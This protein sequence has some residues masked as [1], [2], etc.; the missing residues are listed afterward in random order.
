ML[1]KDNQVKWTE[2]AVKSFNLVKL[3]LSSAPI[4]ISPN[5]TQDFIFFSFSSE[6]TLTVVLMQKREDVEKPIT[7]FSWIIRDGA[8]KYNIIEKQAL[9]LVKALK[10]FRVY[11]L[12]SHILAYVPNAAV[13]DILVQA[14]PEGRRGKWIAAL[15]EY[16]VEIKPTKLIKG[17]GLAKLMDETNL[18][19]L[20]IN[21]IAAISDEEENPFVQAVKNCHECQI[22]EGKQKLQPLPLKPIEL[23]APFQQW[24]LD[25]IGEIHPASSGQHRWI[26]TTT[27]YFTKWIEA[28]P[29]RQ[30]TD[31]VIISFLETNILSHFGCPSK[32]ITDN[33]AVL[34]SKRMI[35]FCYKYNISLGHS[36]A[37]HP[38]GNGLAESSNKSLVNIIKKLL[39]ISKKGWHKKLINALWADRVSQKKS[40]GMSPFE[41][42]YGRDTVFPT[43]LAVP[44][45][46]LLQEAGSEED[47]MQ[48]RINQMIHL[49]QTR[50]EVFQNTCKLQE[51]IK[52]IYDQKAKADT[53]QLDEVVL[54]W[55]ARHEDKGKHGKFE[56]L[57]KGPYKIEAYRGQNAFLL[58]EMNGYECPGGPINGRLLKRYYF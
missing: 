19:V 4:L 42:V 12:H 37:Y 26:L 32:L 16:D 2:E 11:I 33:A 24:G 38:Q 23:N 25:F 40:I 28:I 54:R 30:A 20:H 7:F 49:Q 17:Q 52:N 1:K 58:K 50:E 39:E 36:T 31:A 46:K 13:K 21:L 57:W 14:D 35:K 18:Q 55:Y 8:L 44:V 29:T 47:P 56:N 5:Y 6:H 34:K 9:A 45:V 41:L 10:D 22:F 53:F 15:L 43:S 27:D 48:R 3:A 51:C